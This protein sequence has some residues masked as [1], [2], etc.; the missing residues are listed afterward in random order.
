MFPHSRHND[1][2]YRCITRR[3]ASPKACD[4]FLATIKF[5]QGATGLADPTT[6]LECRRERC[7]KYWILSEGLESFR[8]QSHYWEWAH[9]AIPSSTKHCHWVRV[10]AIGQLISPYIPGIRRRIKLLKAIR[11]EFLATVNLKTAGDMWGMELYAIDLYLENLYGV[12][13][14]LAIRQTCKSWRKGATTVGPIEHI[15]KSGKD[16]DPASAHVM[17]N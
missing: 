6:I 9:S 8:R 12:T 5:V 14:L 10:A 15:V 1:W 11:S 13:T 4:L 2:C 16:M 3:N 17:V 7:D